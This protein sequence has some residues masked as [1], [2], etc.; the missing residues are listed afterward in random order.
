MKYCIDSEK[1][2]E[3]LTNFYSIIDLIDNEIRIMDELVEHTNW[4]GDARDI[5]V[6]SY[7]ETINTISNIPT[8]LRLYLK[9][10]EKVVDEYGE[11]YA[12]IEKSFRELLNEQYQEKNI[13][14]DALL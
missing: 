12:T 8:N 13:G 14:D 9:F 7:H 4:Y 10:M 6:S 3:V 2:D 5:F 1:M 11:G